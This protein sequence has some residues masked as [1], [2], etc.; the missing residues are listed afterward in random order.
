MPNQLVAAGVP[1]SQAFFAYRPATS[2]SAT[3]AAAATR[4]R[5]GRVAASDSATH[6]PSQTRWNS[7]R[8]SASAASRPNNSAA[9]RSFEPSAR[10]SSDHAAPSRKPA[11]RWV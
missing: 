8:I 7:V 10:R 3:A 1:N 5:G 6:A 4:C 2:S 11:S 9:W